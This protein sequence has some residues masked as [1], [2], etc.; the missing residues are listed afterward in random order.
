MFGGGGYRSLISSGENFME[1]RRI[2]LG[3][4]SDESVS[5]D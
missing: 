2:A 1:P 5:C 3:D 4:E